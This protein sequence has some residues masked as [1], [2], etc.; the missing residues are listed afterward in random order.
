MSGY[1]AFT[2]FVEFAKDELAGICQ[3]LVDGDTK[4]SNQ[5]YLCFEM[6]PEEPLSKWQ[7]AQLC[8]A[9]L[10]VPGVPGV[11]VF[12]TGGRKKDEIM[13]RLRDPGTLTK[14]N[15]KSDGTS[16]RTGL[17]NL[18]V[19]GLTVPDTTSD[20]LKYQQLLSFYL[21]TNAKS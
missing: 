8:Q 17:F 6:G 4:P 5:A 20:P 9:R 2:S 13:D 7:V 16:E 11:P 15:L 3:V 10:V 12:V 21:Y 18:E 1:Q 19:E 14:Y